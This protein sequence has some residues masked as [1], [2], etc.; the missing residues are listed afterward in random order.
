MESAKL[1]PCSITPEIQNAA[2]T[3]RL[4]P[5]KVLS[6]F[7]TVPKYQIL[8]SL[9]LVG[10]FFLWALLVMG[11]AFITLTPPFACLKV[12]TLPT[13]TWKESF[14]D[15]GPMMM[16]TTTTVMRKVMLN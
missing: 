6:A 8:V 14:V 15:D 5:D 10:T 13:H 1:V 12:H 16:M 3:E 9:Y 7:G 11:P 4:D 2:V